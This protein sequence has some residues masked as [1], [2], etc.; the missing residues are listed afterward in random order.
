MMK[1]L[2]FYLLAIDS[3]KRPLLI[4]ADKAMRILFS[5]ERE[6]LLD[7]FNSFSEGSSQR[8]YDILGPGLYDVRQVLKL[9]N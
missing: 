1:E 8:T 9:G 6:N 3:P 7:S 2:L 5:S 4:P